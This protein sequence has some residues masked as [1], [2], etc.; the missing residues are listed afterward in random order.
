[1]HIHTNIATL[2]GPVKFTL[3]STAATVDGDQAVVAA[4]VADLTDGHYYVNIHTTANAGGEL[5]GQLIKPGEV[6]YSAA[7]SP[8]NEVPPVVGSAATGGAQFIL[9]ADKASLRYEVSIAGVTPTNSHIHTGTLGNNG[10]VV[11]TLLPIPAPKGTQAV[12]AADITAL[13]AAGYYC[14]VHTTANAGGEMRAQI[15]KQ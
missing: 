12:N 1:M 15:T 7:L 11:Y 2:S 8:T 13:N 14:N 9:T 10:A 6:L 4:D 3:G 5:R